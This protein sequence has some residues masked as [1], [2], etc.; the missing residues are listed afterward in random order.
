MIWY[1]IR[2]SMKINQIFINLVYN[3]YYDSKSYNIW[4][5]FNAFLLVLKRKIS[6]LIPKTLNIKNS[7]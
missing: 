6:K 5:Y 3:N 4:L 7:S 2:E 1:L